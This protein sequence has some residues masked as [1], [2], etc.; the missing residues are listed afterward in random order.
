MILTSDGESSPEL[1]N[2]TQRIFAL[3]TTVIHLKRNA[4]IMTALPETSLLFELI[5]ILDT[6][7]VS[8]ETST[9]HFFSAGWTRLMPCWQ[10]GNKARTGLGRCRAGRGEGNVRVIQSSSCYPMSIVSKCL[11]TTPRVY[12]KSVCKNVAYDGTLW[13]GVAWVMELNT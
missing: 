1:Y 4:L 5:T 12:L 6:V 2:G 10:F 3:C 9:Y 8:Q 11:Y 13:D 7:T